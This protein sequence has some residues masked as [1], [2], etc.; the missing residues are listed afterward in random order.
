MDF[1]SLGQPTQQS[2]GGVLNLSKGGVLDLT[3]AAPSLKKV[4]LG[5]GWDVVTNGPAADLDLS[6]IL[7]PSGV[8]I[9]A[10]NV[11][12]HVV[13]FGNPRVQGA[14]STG[15][16]RTGVGEG[17]DEQIIVDLSQI[18]SN[19]DK[20][21]FVVTI[22]EAQQKRQT[23]GMVK[24][25]FARLVNQETDEEV[26]RYTLTNDYSS[27]TA[28]QFCSLNRKN[29]GWEFE[30]LGKGAIADLNGILNQYM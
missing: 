23:F 9:T 4:I 25:A 19:I 27:D 20:I 13:F 5:C 3:K 28:I 6:A 7:V 29:G 30:A 2:A 12:E 21:V 18:A 15:D 17:D 14:Y 16:N 26:C 8:P 22:F 24:N 1:S 10:T 11:L